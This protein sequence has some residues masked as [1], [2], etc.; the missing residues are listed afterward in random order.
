MLQALLLPLAYQTKYYDQLVDH[1]GFGTAT[2]RH[3]YLYNDTFWGTKGPLQNGCRGPILFY[4]GNE[5]P[6]TSFYGSNGFMTDVLAPEF[7]ALLVFAEERYYGTSQPQ[8]TSGRFDYLS[9]EMVLADYAALITSLRK[10]LDAQNCPCIAF[11]GS[12]G[13]TLTTLF[14][15]K[16]PHVVQGGLAASAPLGY[17][18]QSYWAERNV[19]ATTWFS[20][21]QR[22][23]DNAGSGCYARL[24]AAVDRTNATVRAAGGPQRIQQ[25]FGLCKPPSEPLDSFVYWLTE[26]LE[27]IPQVDYPEANGGL[28]ANP[29]AAACALDWSSASS[30]SSLA[31]VVAWYYG[32]GPAGCIEDATNDQVGGGTPGDGPENRSA[33]GYQSC[34]ETLHAFSTTAGAWRSYEF[35]LPQLSDLC[36]SYYG[37]RPRLDQIEVWSGGYAI[38]EKKLTS[39]LIWSNGRRDPW[40]GGGFLRQSDALPGG[41]VFVM[42]Q[43]AHHHDLRLPI[44][45]DPPELTAVRAKEMEIIRGWIVDAARG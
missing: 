28:P 33:W 44:A 37:V 8:G 36:Y 31:T 29:A 39:N 23:Y 9:T 24:V 35:N 25:A 11:G 12:Y 20:I 34:T 4:T 30:L 40:S 41:A 1:F 22:T 14:R 43:T 2:F 7:G 5:G 21:V 18:S 13:G 42:E 19:S 45:A 10:E 6:I 15:L 17:Y 3:R 27:S 38:A 16:Y 26:A 32:V